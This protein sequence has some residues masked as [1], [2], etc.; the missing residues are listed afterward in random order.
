MYELIYSISLPAR[1]CVLFSAYGARASLARAMKLLR[2][3]KNM[4]GKAKKIDSKKLKFMIKKKGLA[5]LSYS[6]D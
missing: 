3:P 5:I 4:I 2:Q 6:K 1:H